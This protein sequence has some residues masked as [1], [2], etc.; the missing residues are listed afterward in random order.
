MSMEGNGTVPFGR[1]SSE[2]EIC[3]KVKVS[4][5]VLNQPNFEARFYSG[6]RYSKTVKE[7]FGEVKQKCTVSTSCMKSVLFKIFPF[8]GIMGNY[9]V[10]EDLLGDLVSGFTVG[11]MHIPQGKELFYDTR[12]LNLSWL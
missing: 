9:K 6:D 12:K 5:K 1:S 3:P 2:E 7:R 8:I 11:I 10:K 4:R